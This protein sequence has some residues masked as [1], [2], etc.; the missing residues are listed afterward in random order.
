MNR[1][2]EYNRITRVEQNAI[3]VN[4]TLRKNAG[5]ASFE[6]LLKE[7]LNKNEGL[8]FSK[9]AK[10]R[11]DERGIEITDNLLNDLNHA[12]A[13]ARDKGAK[14]VVIFDTQNAFIVNIPN[15]MVITTMA[16]NELKEN[17]FTNID[18]AVII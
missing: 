7:Q 16:G 4:Q 14:D 1:I 5:C 10:E 18:G 13:K 12:V 11:V 8:Q 3:K 6:T 2:N 17:V 15:N 9:H